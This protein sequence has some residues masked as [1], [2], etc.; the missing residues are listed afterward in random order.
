M[1]VLW[2]YTI[3]N[4]RKNKV[5]TL[6]TILGIILSV[7][8]FTAVAEG[9]ISARQYG[10]DVVKKT[11]GSYEALINN[12][13]SK[14][15]ES[16]AR[17]DKIVEYTVMNNLG[18]ADNIG[19]TNNGKPY[20]KV[21]EVSDEFQKMVAVQ[22]TDGRMPEND[23]EIIL[24]AHLYSNGGVEHKIGDILKLDIGPRTID[25]E[26]L[27]ECSEH[28][29]GEKIDVKESR[30]YRVVGF[31]ERF[32]YDIEDYSCP[33]YTA[34][35]RAGSEYSD[36]RIGDDSI[37]FITTSD[38]EKLA[39][40]MADVFEDTDSAAL[41]SRNNSKLL[42]LYGYSK[43]AGLM[44]L[45]ICLVVILFA[46][47]MVGSVML[48]YNSFSISVSERI[49]QFGLLKS[50]GATRRQI[51]MTVIFEAVSLCIIAVPAGLITGCLGIGITLRLL[52]GAFDAILDYGDIGVYIGIHIETSVLLLVAVLGIITVIISA[53]IPALKVVRIQPIDAVKQSGDVQLKRKDVRTLGVTGKI[54]GFEGMIAAKNYRRSRRKYRTTVISLFVSV[55]LF[56]SATSFTHYL[57]QTVER[58]IDEA[59]YDIACGVYMPGEYPEIY[60]QLKNIK[61]ISDSSVVE[62]MHV[63]IK[64]DKDAVS[65][66]YG[67]LLDTADYCVDP[68]EEV[69]EGLSADELMDE[70]RMNYSAYYETVEPYIEVNFVADDVYDKLVRDNGIKLDNSGGIQALLFDDIY[71]QNVVDGAST[72]EDASMFR[73]DRFPLTLTAEFQKKIKGYYFNEMRPEFNDNFELVKENYIY[74][75]SGEDAADEDP[76]GVEEKVFDKDEITENYDICIAGMIKE[77]P[78][79]V[80]N[81]TGIIY[82]K[83][84]KDRVFGDRSSET[85]YNMF[86][87]A[88]DNRQVTKDIKKSVSEYAASHGGAG[89][90]HVE[91]HKQSV[92]SER[93]IITIVKV[94]S[95][96]FIV[97][98]SLIALANVFNTISTNILLR[99]REFAML[100]SVGMA[101]KGTFKMMCYECLLYGIK[102]LLY[103]IPAA[104]AVTYII[105]D[106]L[107]NTI[108]VSFYIP[109]SSIVIAVLSVFAVVFITMIYSMSRIK[110]D[111]ILDTLRKE[112]I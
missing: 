91:D 39:E 62:R 41:S 104:I 47:I 94:F 97:L 67:G 3:R 72:W 50:I 88:A 87:K 51:M 21:C 37:V 96:G 6:V 79:G 58:V 29:E 95:Y 46:L 77:C 38:Y 16:I 85:Y 102:G 84:D 61:G 11:V 82:K 5:R 101:G 49:K 75:K 2:K 66:Y 23:K 17:N 25:G 42:M 110:K 28:M 30:E 83:S 31:Y 108:A 13:D 19:S 112:S 59:N 81:V 34:I 24:P 4:L 60:D 92:E 43:D 105:Y 9:L 71:A 12:P 74:I 32:S 99:R 63:R 45:M 89:D 44:G 93:A 65:E 7:S 53:M 15:M 1:K 80:N 106:S 100:K 20:L 35:T 8:L 90:S 22:L 33:G 64:L 98:I 109:A 40:I 14:I 48:I 36:S 70:C 52:R 103:G 26:V 69:Y 68:G 78:M 111:N 107:K 10:I 57:A 18:Y 86:F 55:V 27:Y 54:F 73:H 76:A 56:I